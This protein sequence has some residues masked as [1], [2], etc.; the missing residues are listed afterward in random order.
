[1]TLQFEIGQGGCSLPEGVFKARFVDVE[2]T[3]HDEYGDGLKFVFEVTDGDR[4]GELGTRITSAKPTPKN[5]AGRI[6]AGIVGESLKAGK[7]VS[8]EPFVGKEYLIQI[9]LTKND[10]TRIATVMA[11]PA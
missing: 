2:P 9:E 4:I 5:A 10:S 3:I 7:T 6:I 11:V 1:M 8:L